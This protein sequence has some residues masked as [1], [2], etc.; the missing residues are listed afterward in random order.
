MLSLKLAMLF[1]F[2]SYVM[3]NYYPPYPQIP[4]AYR[5]Q[6]PANDPLWSQFWDVYDYSGPLEQE[7]IDSSVFQPENL[8]FQTRLPQVDDD[9][10]DRYR[11]YFYRRYGTNFLDN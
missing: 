8:F 5:P 4:V 3:C 10:Y 6:F 11:E 9:A 1:I 7:P 2:S